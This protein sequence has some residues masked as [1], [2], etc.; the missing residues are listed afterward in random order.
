MKLYQ[1][2]YADRFEVHH[3]FAPSENQVVHMFFDWCVLVYGEAPRYFSTKRIRAGDVLPHQP[4]HL[5]AALAMKRRG[6][7]SYHPQ[8]GWAIEPI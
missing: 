7:G 4:L 8:T 5:E 1:I 6:A 3:W 2:E